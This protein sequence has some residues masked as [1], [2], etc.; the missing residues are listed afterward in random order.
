MG[1]QWDYNRLER[2]LRVLRFLRFL[3]NKN[4]RYYHLSRLSLA[5]GPPLL[6]GATHLTAYLKLVALYELCATPPFLTSNCLSNL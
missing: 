1:S 5:F 4:N 3:T 6:Q 2:F